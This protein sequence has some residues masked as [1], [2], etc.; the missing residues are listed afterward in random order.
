M[1]IVIE[2]PDNSGKSTLIGQLQRII[3]WPV[4]SSEG[5]EKHP[6][7]IN[8]RVARYQKYTGDWIFDRHPCV[9]QPIYGQLANRTPIHQHL[10]EDF[11]GA[12]PLFVYC[13][14]RGTLAGH[15]LKQHDDP[16]HIEAVDRNQGWI[17]QTYDRWALKHAHLCYRIGDDSD[18]LISLIASYLSVQPGEVNGT[19]AN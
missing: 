19:A 6:N 3:R 14:G 4:Q 5:P 8:E 10:L 11:Y 12:S 15:V 1:Q 18:R 2:G 16:A 7:E 13:R 9:S 17:E